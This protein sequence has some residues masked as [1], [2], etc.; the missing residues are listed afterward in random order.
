MLL[1]IIA[2]AVNG[3]LDEVT[4]ALLSGGG[5][6]ITLARTLGGAMCLWGGMMRIAEKAG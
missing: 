1:A 5:K 2:G 3:R 4:N 6:A